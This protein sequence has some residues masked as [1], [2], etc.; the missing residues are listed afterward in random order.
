MEGKKEERRKDNWAGRCPTR[1]QSRLRP[2]CP[3]P[4]PFG[5]DLDVIRC[6]GFPQGTRLDLHSPGSAARYALSQKKDN[7]VQA[8]PKAARPTYSIPAAHRCHLM[9]K[10]EGRSSRLTTSAQFRAQTFAEPAVGWAC[11]PLRGG[12][13]VSSRRWACVVGGGVPTACLACAR[14]AGEGHGSV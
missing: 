3:Q 11:E 13:E 12:Q 2:Q 1:D 8:D 6:D 5:P 14:W 10:L 9:Q 4:V 7:R